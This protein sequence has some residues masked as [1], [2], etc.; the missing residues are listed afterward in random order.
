MPPNYQILPGSSTLRW[1]G[2]STR[3][4]M[5][6]GISHSKTGHPLRAAVEVTNEYTTIVIG[7]TLW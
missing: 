5:K 6:W 4:L 7:V 3:G 2:K 1:D